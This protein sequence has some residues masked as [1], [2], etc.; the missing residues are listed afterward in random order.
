[1]PAIANVFRR[2]AVYY[3]RRRLPPNRLPLVKSS[4]LVVNLVTKD[5]E[6]ARPIAAL[7]AARFHFLL[8]S[9]MRLSITDDELRQIFALT[10]KEASAELDRKA[11]A[12]RSDSD[13]PGPDD[14]EWMCKVEATALAIRAAR[15]HDA[16]FNDSIK[17][18]LENE[19]KF[20]RESVELVEDRLNQYAMDPPEDD[21]QAEASDH[22]KRLGVEP[23]DGNVGLVINM[24]LRG[25]AAAYE[26]T[27][28]RCQGRYFADA[29]LARSV[30]KAKPTEISPPRVTT[31]PAAVAA[32][33]LPAVVEASAP[34]NGNIEITERSDPRHP[35]IVHGEGVIED[36]AEVWDIKTARQARSIFDL[37]ARFLAERGIHALAALRQPHLSEF[38]SFLR[39]IPK[40]Y[41]K[42][43]AD[44]SRTCRELAERGRALPTAGRGIRATT[45]N[46]HFSFI[47]ALMDFIA[48][49]GE[50][51]DP[52]IKPKALRW[53]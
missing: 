36:R 8:L 27:E 2:G 5:Q 35:I 33:V 32:M 15:G 24:I 10:V 30:L 17:A 42:A 21:L 48:A 40:S 18:Y 13:M 9:P 53:I 38:R 3:W 34:G 52:L 50:V 39:E 19:K 12:L 1:M 16:L 22:L 46:R 45:I 6:R 31:T 25:W 43:Q 49:Q 44:F 7:V 23:T 41:G 37:L 29:D 14:Q 47:T 4:N 51:I 20:S 11:I 28:E 26:V